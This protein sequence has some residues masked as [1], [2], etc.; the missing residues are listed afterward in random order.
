MQS[1]GNLIFLVKMDVKFRNLQISK[2][3]NTDTNRIFPIP[4]KVMYILL[5]YTYLRN[6]SAVSRSGY[7]HGVNEKFSLTNALVSFST[8]GTYL[9]YIKKK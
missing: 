1:L 9:N 6:N 7:L 8:E 2:I 5:G 3:L 4:F